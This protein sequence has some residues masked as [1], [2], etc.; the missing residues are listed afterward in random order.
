MKSSFYTPLDVQFWRRRFLLIGQ[1]RKGQI[2]VQS[3][4]SNP[5]CENTKKICLVPKVFECLKQCAEDNSKK[6]YVALGCEN[7]TTSEAKGEWI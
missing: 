1:S 4:C 2:G 7:K 3:F 6:H 5:H